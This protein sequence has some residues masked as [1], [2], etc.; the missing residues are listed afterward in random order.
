MILTSAR[1]SRR[2]ALSGSPRSATG[3]ASPRG[4]AAPW[5][6]RAGG[7]ALAALFAFPAAYL[8]WRNFT[9]DAD[10]GLLL[11]SRVLEP[12]GRT[13]LLASLVSL[14][15]MVLGTALAWVTTRTDVIGARMWRVVLPI[16]LVFPTFIGAAALI[17]TMNPGGLANDLLANVGVDRT[18]EVRGLLGA[19]FVLTLF[20]YP[21]VYLPVAAA[22]RSL[23]GSLEDS[24]RVLGDTAWAAFRRIC[25][26]QIATAI[27]AGTLLVFLYTVSDFG[28]VELVRYD[29]LTRAIAT[30]QLANRPVALALSLILLV[31]AASVVSVERAF[32]R[33]L[34]EGG[35]HRSSRPVI[36]PL[37]RLRPLVTGLTVL[38]AAAAIGGPMAALVDWSVEGVLRSTRGGRPLTIDRADVLD[39]TINTFQVSALAAVAAVAAVLPVAYL[40]GRYRS[41][42]GSV[43]NAIIISTFALPGLLIALS[44]RFWTLQ[45]SLAFDV[46]SDTMGLLV[47]A[48]VVRFGSLAMGVTLIAVRSV[49]ERLDD[50][51]ATLGANRLR[52]FVT[53]DVPVMAPALAAAAGLVLLSVMKELPISLLISPIGFS[54]LATRIFSSFEDAF[55]AEAG[56]MALVLV[57]LSSVFSWFLVLRRADHLS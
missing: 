39:A 46:L 42:A 31:V 29:T 5:P 54:N 45:S 18:P 48:Y 56:I 9:E 13:L 32:S 52:R 43:A 8:V 44:M 55:V 16:P 34:P 50:A 38:A 17:R 15:A 24:A 25:L 4:G 41:R 33:R 28:A 3:P 11:T 49:P 23:S 12:L 10:P 40:V 57:L 14:S 30:N 6:L 37:G 19:W 2:D 47:F 35:R 21:Y 53:I 7:L 36:Y 27:G 51:A 22:L 26:P 20:T 1:R